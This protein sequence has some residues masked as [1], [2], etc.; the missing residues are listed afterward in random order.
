MRAVETAD[1][2]LVGEDGL[3]SNSLSL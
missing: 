2:D 3:V 1:S